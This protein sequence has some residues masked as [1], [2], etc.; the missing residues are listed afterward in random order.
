MVTVSAADLAT[1]L[2]A[3]AEAKEPN[4]KKKETKLQLVLKLLGMLVLSGVME[5]A[6]TVTPP[7][8]QG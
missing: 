8:S 3:L 6:K 4:Q 5:T 7:T 2:K 1:L